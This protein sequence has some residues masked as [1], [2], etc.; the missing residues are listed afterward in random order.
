SG[1]IGALITPQFVGLAHTR[2]LPFASSLCGACRQVCPVRINIPDLLLHLRS[3]VQEETKAPKKPKDSPVTERTSM[4]LWAWAMKRPAMYVLGAR[5]ARLAQR[6]IAG[7]SRQAAWIRRLTMYP[8]SRWT[9]GRDLPE[10]DPKPFR[11]RWKQ[12]SGM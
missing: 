6:L 2:E 5:M 12:I 7:N 3:K 8:L 11:D 9:A 4:R 10:L 1:P